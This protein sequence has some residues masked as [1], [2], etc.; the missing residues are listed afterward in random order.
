MNDNLFSVLTHVY[1]NS[2]LFP[3]K[4]DELIPHT[5]YHFNRMGGGR[6]STTMFRLLAYI[7]GAQHYQPARNILRGNEAQCLR[8]V[9]WASA[10]KSFYRDTFF[11]LRSE[12]YEFLRNILLRRH[13]KLREISKSRSNDPNYKRKVVIVT[14]GGTS[15]ANAAA[16]RLSSD[17]ERRMMS[18]FQKQ[19]AEVTICC[20]F[21]HVNTVE[22][23]VEVFWD[24]DICVGV[25]G[26]GLSNCI[27]GS[28]GMVLVEFQTH[29]A[30][31]FDSFMKIAHLAKGH[32]L[33]YDVRNAPVQSKG[34]DANAGANLQDTLL[35]N[36]AQTALALHKFSIDH[37]H[38]VL[39]QLHPANMSQPVPGKLHRHETDYLPDQGKIYTYRPPRTGAQLLENLSQGELIVDFKAKDIFLD[40]TIRAPNGNQI[41]FC[42]LPHVVILIGVV[43]SDR[44]CGHQLR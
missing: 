39:A 40:K 44:Y 41:V 10:F 6:S 17:T 28:P 36:L 14:R 37:L 38:V 8:E 24:V 1:M 9:T 15:G 26:A 2:L 25:H 43:V 33:M 20:D 23:L 27:F 13:A 12:L 31:G 35:A 32:Y 11:Q 19:G 7:F 4:R 22:K 29:H 30:F 18:A 16:R 5:L 34:G 3:S 21:A 42:C